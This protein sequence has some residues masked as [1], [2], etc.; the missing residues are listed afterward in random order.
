MTINQ[1]F[2][3]GDILFLEPMFR[4]FH[5]RNGYKPTLWVRDHF[6]HL[7]E[8]IESVEMVSCSNKDIDNAN[9]TFDYFPARFAN[10]I[11][12]GYDKFDHHDAENMMLDKYRLAS[13]DV[14]AWKMIH[15]KFNEG[16]AMELM[17]KKV[18]NTKDYILV[19]ETSGV[20]KI[21]IPIKSDCKIIKME[22]VPGYSLIDWY[23]V[24]ANA[25]ENHHISTSTF[26]LF[27]AISNL[28]GG[29]LATKIFLYPRP[30]INGY[31][32]GLRG[33]EKLNPS[34]TYT[35]MP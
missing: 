2:G 13:I 17:E 12:R 7:Q 23:L 11:Y 30:E 24:I 15:L 1:P 8:Y 26:F 19:N 35:P 25:K 4:F 6:L 20:G 31:K 27:Q 29:Q 22:Y 9:M 14:E 32:D 18:G 3:L 16:R 5:K 34:F 33:I 21:E 28:F 10:Q